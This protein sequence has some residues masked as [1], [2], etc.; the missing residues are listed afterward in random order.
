ME[1]IESITLKKM[2]QDERNH[3]LSDGLSQLPLPD[4]LKIGFKRFAIPKDMDEFSGAICYGQRMYLAEQETNDFG[5]ILRSI[6][7]YYYPIV[8]KHSFLDE[9]AQLFG[10]VILH[11][12]VIDLYPV[13]MHLVSL[14]AELTDRE[15]KLLHREPSKQEKAAHI[16]K[17]APFADLTAL[18]FLRQSL[19]KTEEEV[20]LTPYNDCLVRFMLAK[21]QNAFNERLTEV[22]KKESESKHK[23]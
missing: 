13:A 23:S 16:E 14:M 2:I 9:K 12:P 5:I 3:T 22:Y 4:K 11:L 10:R 20:L 19:N 21:E 6:T 18:D 8:S 7:G 1:R 17:L 15:K